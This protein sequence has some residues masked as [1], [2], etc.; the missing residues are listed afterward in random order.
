MNCPN[1]K[2]SM[3]TLP[4]EGV[5][6][7][8]CDGCGGHWLDKGEIGR[9]VETRGET[10]SHAQKVQ[11]FKEKGV[12][13]SAG[14]AFGCPKCKQPMRKFN[15]ALNSGVIL[16]K[17]QGHGF[18]FDK[19]EL[20]KI[21][22]LNEE[23]DREFDTAHGQGSAQTAST[24]NCPR[25]KVPLN[26]VD[27]EKTRLDLC[28]KCAGFWCDE[29]ELKAVIDTRDKD[30]S[31]AKAGIG[32]L[33]DN[34]PVTPDQHVDELPC[35]MCGDL[36]DRM[37]YG[38][39][40]GIVIDRCRKGHG[41]WLD[42]GEIEA[43]QVYAEKSKDTAPEVMQQFAKKLA[44]VRAETEKKQQEMASKLRVSRFGRVNMFM[45]NLY[46]NGYY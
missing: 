15:Y 14:K 10:F 31:Q 32:D 46:R 30:F 17:C 28:P 21:Q 2:S 24:K 11:A 23:Y 39:G 5:M 45:Q 38:Y 26:E 44:T 6:I 9:I 19:G 22:I 18:W 25:C 40:S 42:K 41:V 13:A 35:I 43:I 37:P 27:Y 33:K 36:L 1:C 12:D 16:D 7:D 3:K 34:K 29:G 4:Y 8:R 20:E